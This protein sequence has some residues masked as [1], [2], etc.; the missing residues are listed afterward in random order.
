MKIMYGYDIGHKWFS[1]L[2]GRGAFGFLV[3]VVLKTEL[4]FEIGFC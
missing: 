4:V 3:R 1:A 2:P